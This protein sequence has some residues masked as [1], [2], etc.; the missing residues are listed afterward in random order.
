MEGKVILADPFK[1]TGCR[2]CELVC[3]FKHEGM[4]APSLSRIRIVKIHEMGFNNPISCLDCSRMPC[5]DACPTGAC[6]V[7][8]V[9][10]ALCIGCRECVAACPFGAMDFNPTT[11]VSFKCDLCEGDP[12]CVKSCI[13]GALIFQ[14]GSNQAKTKRRDRTLIRYAL[15]REA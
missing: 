8:K 7:M 3:S 10:T 5:V 1:C 6:Q 2:V 13:P 11:R 12:E 15:V 4:F 9:E 14:I